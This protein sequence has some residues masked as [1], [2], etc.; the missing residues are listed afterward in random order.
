MVKYIIKRILWMIPILLGV[1]VLIFTLMYFIPGDPAVMILGTDATEAEYY[2][3]NERLGLNDPYIIQLGRYLY[4]VFL[5]GDFGVSYMRNTPVVDELIT[6][7]PR[8]AT[9]GLACIILSFG[10]SVPLGIS[11][12]VHQGKWQDKFLMLIALVGVSLPDFWFGLMFVLLFSVKLG[13]LPS[14]GIGGI[15]YYVLPCLAG[16]V[17][18]IAGLARQT[19]S[20][21]LEVIRSDFVV[22]ARSKG[23]SERKVI[24]GH[25]L[26]NALIPIVTLLGSRF[27]MI[28]AGTVII[29][30]LFSIPGVGLYMVNAVNNRDYPVVRGCVI[31]LAAFAAVAQLLTDLAYAFIDPRIGAQFAGNKKRKKDGKE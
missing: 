27:G 26:P 24:L 29:E 13:W 1:A 22:T 4:N 11:A 15:E 31:I 19:R 7:I 25:A 5:R 17:G 2:A 20:S 8:T 14:V 30:T 18:S 12:A 16:S 21:M 28:I 23:I 3:M 10:I 9:L 6:R